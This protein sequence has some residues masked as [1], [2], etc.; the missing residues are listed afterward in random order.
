MRDKLKRLVF[1]MLGKDP[2]AVV[3][4]FASGDPELVRR[5]IEEVRTLTPDREHH[6]VALPQNIPAGE[7]Y[8]QL[9]RRFRHKRIGLAPVLFTGQPHPL[10]G[11]AF[12]LAPSK[13]LAYNQ[14]L[15][16][17][18]LRPTLASWLFLRGVPKDHIGDRPW[19]ASR[20]SGRYTEIDGRP[21]DPQR[22]RVAILSPYFPYPML[23]GGAVRIYHLL[24]EAAREFDIV[25]FA[26][27]RQPEQQEIEPLRE[28]CSKVVVVDPPV[29]RKPRWASLHPPEVGEYESPLMRRM[30]EEH[31]HELR[32]VEYTQ[33]A[34]YGGDVLVEHDVTWD[35]FQQV[36]RRGGSWWDY[37]RWRWFESRALQ[38]YRE[39]VVMSTK[40][41]GLLGR[42][43]VIGNGVD[44][45]RF[46]PE[47]EAP[48]QRL[49]FVGSFNHFPNIDAFRFFMQDVWPQLR[50]RCPEITLTVV[51][52][53]DHLQYWRRFSGGS[54]LP[55]DARIRVL[56]FV[57]DVKP[58]YVEA[59]LV[60]VPTRVSAGTNLKV[61][62]A[63]AME[64]AVLSTPSGCA[65]I[66][67]RHAE[68][69]WIADS[70]EEFVEGAATL[71][72]NA[73]LR[74]RIARAGR[75]IAEANFD[76]RVLGEMQ[77]A[78]WRGMLS[79]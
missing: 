77:R 19:S 12:A 29:Y 71:L 48:G 31:P 58:L 39:V 10:R 2:D 25:L 38:R 72:R 62:E 6:V 51:A 53:R 44:L 42:G 75:A 14:H 60:I 47:P 41:R 57:R 1:G 18:H 36:Q 68:S 69:L 13:I 50:L 63:M 73:A 64:R 32:Q 49:L 34:R 17:H 5:M 4:C 22:R 45:E 74:N 16:R 61:L 26:F 24:R 76:W 59:N 35:L 56:D 27:A 15:E 37:V 79:R 43:V 52:G 66:G 46:Q 40:D 30:L 23:H 55:E 65:G 78:L 20:H 28:F 3:V 8:L 21:F 54:K 67:L 7:F 33:L 11:I 70:A 9:R